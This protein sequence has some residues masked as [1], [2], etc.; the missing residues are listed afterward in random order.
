MKFIKTKIKKKAFIITNMW[1][2]VI[3]FFTLFL[4]LG[5]LFYTGFSLYQ[6]SKITLSYPDDTEN[7]LL[8]DSVTNCFQYYDHFTFSYYSY[9]I[10]MK[11]FDKNNLIKCVNYNNEIYVN[12][13]SNSFN[14]EIKTKNWDH[15]DF[16]KSFPVILINSTTYERELGNMLIGIQKNE[17]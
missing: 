17:K 13:R 10:D 14:K 11:S 7:Q 4:M 5:V 1:I 9:L 15:N 6:L 12:I 16:V 3:S 8:F 2:L